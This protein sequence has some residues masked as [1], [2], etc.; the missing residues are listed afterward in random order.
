MRALLAMAPEAFPFVFT[1]TDLHRLTRLVDVDPSRILTSFAQA[2]ASELDEVELLVTGWGAPSLGASELDAMPNLRGVVHWG[3]G[4]AFLDP[5]AA[6]RGIAVSSARAANAIPVAEFTVAM[7]VLAA[8]DAFWASRSYVQQQRR[9]DRELELPHAGLF[10]TTVGIVGASSIGTR[11]LQMLRD[12]DVELLLFDPSVGPERA[13]QLGAELVDDLEDLA[14]RSTILS[15][16]APELPHLRGMIS[17]EVLSA[18]PDRATVINTARGGLIDQ[19][20]LIAELET[21]RI[22]AILDVTDP[23]VLPPGHPLY[24]LPNVFLTP[25]LAGSMGSELRRLGS[26]ATA[27]VARF[28]AGQPFQHPIVP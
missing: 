14:S 12:Y 28:V 13:A 10:G 9:I 11:V 2:A 16:H 23:D 1:E 27:E 8:K 3:G 24:T 7:I 19:E 4:V 17:R 5:A 21:G 20:A 6:E 26:A 15:I 25:H 18:L 22:R